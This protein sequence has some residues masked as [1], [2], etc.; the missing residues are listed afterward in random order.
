MNKYEI[1]EKLAKEKTI[2]KLVKK[3]NINSGFKKDLCQDL[4]IELLNKD[5]NLINKLYNN[6]EYVYYIMKMIKNNVN[7]ITSPFY[8]DYEKFI[9]ITEPIDGKEKEEQE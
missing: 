2:E 1:I 3:Y 7:S 5:E 4:Y 6:K 8:K 9:K